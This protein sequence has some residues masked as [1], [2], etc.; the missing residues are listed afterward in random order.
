VPNAPAAG[1]TDPL[2]GRAAAVLAAI[3]A[4]LAVGLGAYA[5]HAA[6]PVDGERLRTAVL[7]MMFHSLAVL[8]MVG[9]AGKTLAMVRWLFLAGVALFSG[10]LILA[11]LADLSTRLAPAGGIALMLAWLMLAIALWR[12][13]G[14]SG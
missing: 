2:P 14:R 10:S 5:A 9:R 6:D 12:G 13:E 1:D 11:A 8:A 3:L 7:Y 4:G